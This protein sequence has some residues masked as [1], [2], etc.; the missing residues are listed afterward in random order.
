MSISNIKEDNQL[1]WTHFSISFLDIRLCSKL[2][3]IYPNIVSDDDIGPLFINKTIFENVINSYFLGKNYTREEILN[4]KWNMYITKDYYIKVDNENNV[5]KISGIKDK[6]YVS[7]LDVSGKLGEFSF[8]YKN[9]SNK[10][11]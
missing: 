5:T 8:I 2:Y 10:K 1:G 3:V 6:W 11:V 7:Y 9:D 4:L